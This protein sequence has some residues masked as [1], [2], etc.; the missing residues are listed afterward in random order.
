VPLPTGSLVD[1]TIEAERPTTKAEV[2]AAFERAADT[3]ALNG[4]LA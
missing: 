2:N 1:L 4:S 3:G